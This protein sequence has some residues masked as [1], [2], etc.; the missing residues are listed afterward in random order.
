[1]QKVQKKI[2]IHKS[3]AQVKSRKIKVTNVNKKI[4]NGELNVRKEW[5]NSE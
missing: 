1:M 4:T 3:A 5:G 2:V